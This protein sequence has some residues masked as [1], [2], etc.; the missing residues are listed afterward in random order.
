[1]K[2]IFYGR[3]NE[4]TKR[5]I[6]CPECESIMETT[7]AEMGP[8]HPDQ[9]DGD[10]YTVTCPVCRKNIYLSAEAVNNNTLYK[11]RGRYR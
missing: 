2:I 6:W 8:V 1:V 9:R 3:T 4:E 11:P 5:E 7:I 10:Y